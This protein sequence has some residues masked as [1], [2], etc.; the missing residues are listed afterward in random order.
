[1]RLAAT[2]LVGTVVYM[3]NTSVSTATA[4][5]DFP[6]TISSFGAYKYAFPVKRMLRSYDDHDEERVGGL[7]KFKAGVSKLIE[8]TK[9]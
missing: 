6:A 2:I 1:M 8:S 4:A 7:E 9:L 5:I 3:S